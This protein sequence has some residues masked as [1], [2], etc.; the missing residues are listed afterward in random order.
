MLGFGGAGAEEGVAV[1]RRGLFVE[2]DVVDVVCGGV[3]VGGVFMFWFG[4]WVVVVG[5]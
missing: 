4:R 1:A 2:G 3:G 5:G